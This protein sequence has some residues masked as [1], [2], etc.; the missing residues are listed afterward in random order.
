MPEEILFQSTIDVKRAFNF[1][2]L[3][4]KRAKTMLD[5]K[6]VKANNCTHCHKSPKILQTRKARGGTLAHGTWRDVWN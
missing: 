4:E 6:R 2:V 3:S 5:R 1:R